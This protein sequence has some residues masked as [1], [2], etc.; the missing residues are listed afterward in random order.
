MKVALALLVAVSFLASV[1]SHGGGRSSTSGRGPKGKEKGPGGS[2][3]TARPSGR[4]PSPRGRRPEGRGPKAGG[5]RRTAGALG[6]GSER[7]QWR[8][9]VDADITVKESAKFNRTKE[10]I[11]LFSFDR[12]LRSSNIST[13]FSAY[14]FQNGMA[15]ARLRVNNTKVCLVFSV[16]NFSEAVDAISGRNMSEL[17]TTPDIADEYIMKTDDRMTDAEL[18]AFNSTSPSLYQICQG[19]RKGPYVIIDATTV[20]TG[21]DVTNLNPVTFLSINGKVTVYLKSTL[22]L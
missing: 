16:S 19:R 15:A 1:Q 17:V 11:T 21:E 2:G 10:F 7:R 9:I 3:P 14:D 8:R 5:S 4:G 20:T 12:K 13:A 18:V 6:E 22:S